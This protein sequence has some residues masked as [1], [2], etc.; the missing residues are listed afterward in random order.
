MTDRSANYACGDGFTQRGL[1]QPKKAETK[2]EY[3][4][5]K[6]REAAE[7]VQRYKQLLKQA[8][9]R[10]DEYDRAL[11]FEDIQEGSGP[12]EGRKRITKTKKG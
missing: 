2:E 10:Y 6:H 9:E 4:R 5:R 8:K 11:N 3:Q 12:K 7:D 1:M